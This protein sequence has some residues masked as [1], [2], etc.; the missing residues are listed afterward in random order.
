VGF[1]AVAVY[2]SIILSIAPVSKT[3][4]LMEVTDG[5]TFTT[6]TSFWAGGRKNRDSNP[7]RFRR[8]SSSQEISDQLW[9]PPFLLFSGYLVIFSL[10]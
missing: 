10:G 8:F 7:G 2:S 6:V 4:N 9:F 3:C 1:T 5:F